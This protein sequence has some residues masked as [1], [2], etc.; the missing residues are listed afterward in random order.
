M[1]VSPSFAGE[2][3]FVQGEVHGVKPE[4]FISCVG[5]LFNLLGGY[6]Q[7]DSQLQHHGIGEAGFPLFVGELAGDGI[8]VVLPID[9]LAIGEGHGA[10]QGTPLPLGVFIAVVCR[11]RHRTRFDDTA[12]P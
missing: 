12:A 4:V 2:C 3:F 5:V 6:L 7:I 8:G 9:E 1:E 11:Q 10:A